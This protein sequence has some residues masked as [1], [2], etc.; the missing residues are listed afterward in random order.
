M[1]VEIERKFLVDSLDAVNGTDPVPVRQGYLARGE[2]EEVRV[3]RQGE[4]FT[5][6]VKRGSGLTRSECEIPLG[7]EQFQELWPATEGA[8]V[9]KSRYAVALPD[10]R[11]AHVDVFDGRLLG[12]ATVEVEFPSESEARAFD[13]PAWFGAEV[14][15]DAR[16]ANRA[17][18]S[19][20]G[21]PA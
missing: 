18:S 5:L 3:R 14:T 15:E 17:L 13:P 20:D 1:H 16:Y 21:V 6:T 4:E 12:L 8:R 10:G 7:P 11:T 9:T 2:G 19:A